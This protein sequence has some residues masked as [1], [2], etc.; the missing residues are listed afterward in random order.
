[1]YFLKNG[2]EADKS[3]I[4]A[5]LKLESPN[6]LKELQ[7]IMGMLNYLRRFIS[8]FAER[9]SQIRELLKKDVEFSWLPA[10]EAELTKIKQALS[11][12]PVLG[13]FDVK[14]EV[15]IQCDASQNGLGCTLMQE[16]RPV[17]YA[18][19]SLTNTEKSY[20]QIEKELL[21]VVFATNKFHYYIYGRLVRV[22]TDHKP[23]L[24][25]IKKPVAE[26]ISPRLQ[27]MK[28]KLLK[29]NLN[30]QF[31]P[32]KEMYIA[33]LLSRSMLKYKVKD[34]VELEEV[35]HIIEKHLIISDEKREMFEK[36]TKNDKDLQEVIKF[37]RNGWPKS[38]KQIPL[39]LKQYWQY[40]NLIT[41]ENNLLFL[42][43]RLIVPK[44]LI[45]DTLRILHSSHLGM[46]KT[47]L[48]ARCNLFW[49]N[50][51]NDIELLVQKCKEC[52][53]YRNKN[54]KEPMIPHNVPNRPFAKIASD[55][56][57]YAGKRYMVVVDYFSG[58][59]EICPMKYI[60]S[61]EVIEKLK[62]IFSNHGIPEEL[63]ADNM[64]YSS[65]KMQQFAREWGFKITT[66]SPY[67][68]KSNGLAEK[69]V[70]IAKNL[71]KKTCDIHY[72][73]LEYRNTP[74]LSTG[75]TPAQMLMGRMLKSK[76]PSVQSKLIPKSND[77][78]MLKSKIDRKRQ[79]DKY[80]YDRTAKERCEF[81]EGENVVLRTDRNW[82][83]ARIEKKITDVPRSY[84]VRD[85][86]NNLFRRNTSFIRKSF[87][88]PVFKKQLNDNID[89]HND[90]SHKND[91]E[92][93]DRNEQRQSVLKDTR[94]SKRTIKLPSRF[95]DC[96]MY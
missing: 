32:G 20:S 24:S 82:V 10:H 17:H 46:T 65:Y 78:N 61:D 56:L 45:K 89:D 15:T 88:E 8:N 73:L 87:N 64:P 13:I 25:L 44:V 66:S 49:P 28:I 90:I 47:K 52:E 48:R 72:A 67:Y 95:K 69:A 77:N 39:S 3:M 40:Q 92:V 86:N 42:N 31:S 74:R 26:V 91:V 4:E 27:R 83:P 23:L 35:V 79:L 37:C 60:N 22:I 38:I 84:I 62:I 34:D 55:L 76:I 68:T 96:E 41:L 57:E 36:E 29:Y 18:S 16:G 50:M 1:M 53:K 7:R 75:L 21:G 70:G 71:L 58:W 30:L 63:I 19:R 59:L 12:R 5:I 14:K 43:D 94:V 80:Y 33:D 85:D 93:S 9:T 81:K 51:N 2:V 11:K 54:C 6:N